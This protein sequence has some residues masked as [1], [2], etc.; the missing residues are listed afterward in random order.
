MSVWDSINGRHNR[1]KLADEKKTIE[2]KVNAR[3]GAV[4]Q[5]YENRRNA[6]DQQMRKEIAL[7]DQA[8]QPIHDS[9]ELARALLGRASASREHELETRREPGEAKAARGRDGR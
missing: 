8:L 7:I 6:P 4:V 2:R 1:R 5:Q 3:R 9:L